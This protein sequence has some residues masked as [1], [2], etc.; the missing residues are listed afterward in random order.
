[1]KISVIVPVMDEAANVEPLAS[2]V[3]E[4]IENNPDAEI[5]FVD[6]GSRD[7]TLDRLRKLNASDARIRYLSFSRNFG[8]QAALRAGLEKSTGDCVIMMDGDFQHPPALIPSMLA[9]HSEGWDIVSMKRIEP[10]RGKA[11]RNGLLKRITSRGFYS[12]VNALSD[13][14]MEPGAAD[15][16]LVSGRVRDILISMKESDLFLRGAVPWTGFSAAEISYTAQARRSGSTKYTFRKML[17]L[18]IDGIASFSVRPL[19]LTAVAGFAISAAGLAYAAYA[20]F[21][22]IFTSRTVEGWTSILA[23]VL[24]IG[25]LQLVSLGILGEY[26]GKVFIQTKSR[27]PYILKETSANVG[28]T[29]KETK[30]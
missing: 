2:A 4:A 1:M 16:R 12:I 5:L 7:D 25:G 18:A 29:G 30:K 11:G 15:F 17:S 22:R 26:L 23:S 14:K 3:F 19:R 28:R 6:D 13:T 20:L 9:K 27:P 21:M 8:H 24:I 10:G